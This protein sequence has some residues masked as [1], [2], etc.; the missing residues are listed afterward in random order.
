M[1]LW[2]FVKVHFIKICKPQGGEALVVPNI[3]TESQ[4]RQHSYQSLRG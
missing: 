2:R 4:T 3:S 1:G